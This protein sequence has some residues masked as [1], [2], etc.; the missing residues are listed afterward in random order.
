MGAGWWEQPPS[1]I[2]CILHVETTTVA[3]ATGLRRLIIPGPFQEPLC[4]TGAPFDHARNQA[5][6]KV[7]DSGADYCFF[8]DSDVIAPRDTIPRLIA[9]KEPII[10][11]IYYRRSPPHGVPVAIK[12]G[13]WL[14]SFPANKVIDVDLV[15]AGCLLVHRS[16]FQSLPP[17]RP[18][19]HWFDWRVD[20]SSVEGTQPNLS[21]DFTFCVH[22]Q[23]NGY[24]VCVDT[25]IQCHHI[26]FAKATRGALTPLDTMEVPQ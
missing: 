10:S 2:V 9:R 6:M 17:Q 11:G 3:W 24:K 4:L 22:A 26:G 5:A 25:S 7:L 20:L 12:N 16:V 19:R 18:G 21:E 8:L 13:S 23:K 1:V 15:G 14:T